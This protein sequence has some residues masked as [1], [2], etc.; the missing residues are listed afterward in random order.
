[1]HVSTTEV[2]VPDAMTIQVTDDSLIAELSDG[3]TISVPLCWY[4][5]LVHGTPEERDNWELIG[6][7]E[8]ST[9]L[10]STKTSAS[11]DSWPAGSPAKANAPSSGGWRPSRPAF[12]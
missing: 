7:G 5:R 11:R 8:A 10:T 3:R 12:R 6:T 9:G 4:P 2:N 1:M